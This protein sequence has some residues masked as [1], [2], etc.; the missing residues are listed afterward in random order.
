MKGREMIRMAMVAG[1]CLLMAGCMSNE[2]YLAAMQDQSVT[3]MSGVDADGRQ[4]TCVNRPVTGSH[5]PRRECFTDAERDVLREAGL[6]MIDRT[7]QA[8]ETDFGPIRD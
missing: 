8:G 7:R 6:D 5:R 3:A 2:E 4:I 1:A